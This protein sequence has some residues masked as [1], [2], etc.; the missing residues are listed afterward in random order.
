VELGDRT[1][2]TQSA[3]VLGTVTTRQGTD[4]GLTLDALGDT[5][6]GLR[7]TQPLL[8]GAGTAINEAPVD[9]AR[10]Q[11]SQNFYALQQTLINTVSTT[12]TQYTSLVQAQ[13]SVAIQA[14]ALAR[15]RQQLEISAALVAA[16]R[17][18]ELEL[19]DSRR[20]IANAESDLL[21]ARN[22][23][24]A[25]NTALLDQIGTDQSILFSTAADQVAELF[26]AAVARVETYDLEVLLAIAYQRRPDYLQ[27][28]L[29]Q[30]IAQL[31]QQR[32]TDDLRWQLNVEGD[33]NLGDF[34]QTTVGLV[35]RRTFDEP[36]LETAQ[37]RSEVQVLQQENRL[38][39][40]QIAIRNEISNQLNT[41]RANLV[42]VEAARRATENARLQLAV[43]Q[44]LFQRGRGRTL[45]EIISQEENLV[46]AQNQQLQ[47]E[48]TFL[49]SVVALDQA[50]GLT[51]ATWSR[52]VDFLPALLPPE[53][54]EAFENPAPDLG[55]PAE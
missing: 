2:L 4:I 10:L 12:V 34:S 29:D 28:L 18:A 45:F 47:A 23:L 46:S 50:V 21:V 48:I 19:A 17:R 52:E 11:E 27:T 39:Q 44:E 40:Q 53:S 30:D 6:I 22:N 25:A 42:R 55:L 9:I 15:R 32:A 38:L 3:G 51:L 14:Q 54:Q 33:A 20:A 43:T 41:V 31:N 26:Q 36:D 24:E 16:G 13:E 8:R 49:N 5:P 35:A 7:F 37:V 1:T